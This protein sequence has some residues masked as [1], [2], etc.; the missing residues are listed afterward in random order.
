MQDTFAE[1]IHIHNINS[2]N[3][4]IQGLGRSNIRHD[5]GLLRKMSASLEEG[6]CVVLFYFDIAR[7]HEIENAAGMDIADRIIG[8]FKDT[9]IHGMGILSRRHVSILAAESL[10]GEDFI[11]ITEADRAPTLGTLEDSAVAYRRQIKDTMNEEFRLLTG[12]DMDIHIGHAVIT[13]KRNNTELMLYNATKKA[14]AIAK[15]FIN[16]QSVRYL[17]EFKRLLKEGGFHSVYQPI[18]SIRSA[19]VLG[20]EALVRGP[21]DSYFHRP[22]VI[23]S[24]AEEEGLLFPLEKICRESALNG[25]GEVGPDQKVFINIHPKTV[26]DLHF[27]EDETLGLIDALGMKP[28]NVVFEITER[29]H[30]TDFN[31]LNKTLA[32]YR[33]Q[34]FLVALDD[35]GSGFSSLQSIAE[36]RPDYI[37]IDMSLVRGIHKDRVKTALMETFVTFSEKIGCEIIAEGVEEEGELAALANIGVHYG[38]GYFFGKPFR[39]KQAAP[40]ETYL[41]TLHFVN[42]GRYRLLKHA[43]PIGDIVDEAITI[44]EQTPVKDVKTIF[45]ADNS[46]AGIVVVEAGKPCGL[47][48]R[49][50]LDRH[51]GRKYGVAL[52]Y[53]KPIA[54]IMDKLPLIVDHCAPVELVSQAAMSRNK[55]KLYD[56]I[57]VTRTGLMQ[58]VVSVQTLLDTMTR[59]RVELAKGANPLT[60]LP[61]NI[62]IE[63]EHL[64]RA[65]QGAAF[66][67]IFIDLDHFK[68]YND[69]YGFEKGDEVIL[70]TANLLKETVEHHGGEDDFLSHIGGD[71]FL[72]FTTDEHVDTLCRKVIES[73]D[74]HI[75]RLYSSE[76]R[77]AGG[78]FALDR[79][80]NEKWFP[81]VSVSMA[82][83]DCTAGT[84]KDMKEISAKMAQLKQYAKSK[85]G[86]VY[87]RDRRQR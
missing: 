46:L 8:L 36:I 13:D 49:Q 39:S 56:N 65:S 41:K 45:D 11:L 85:P 33:D 38:Q 76:D 40:R 22:D 1:G 47:V 68:S 2:G 81:F 28:K 15:G 53:E 31:A 25:L 23:F 80:G 66:S 59:I 14:Y 26:N 48:M 69:K 84:G 44:G 5:P 64:R 17:P 3:G 27:V 12:R 19:A 72:I 67:I 50:H 75:D 74:K 42:N 34:G 61:G 35:V 55:I 32:N 10:W 78:I 70:Y 18:I 83:L 87:V 16:M 63:Q 60:G 6:K 21:E 43:F 4:L 24:F 57:I 52:Y 62:A 71:D 54:R 37:K 30:I 9:L 77:A 29:H 79:S 58:G 20:W 51:L 73:F 82:V 7:L 86:S